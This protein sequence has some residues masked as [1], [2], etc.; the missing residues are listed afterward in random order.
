MAKR[1]LIINQNDK[2]G[3]LTFTGNI[4]YDEK[5]KRWL[6]EFICGCG[7][8]KQYRTDI[9]I[10]GKRKSCGCKSPTKNYNKNLHIFQD[11]YGYYILWNRIKKRAKESNIEFFITPDDIKNQF[12]EQNGKCF[13]THKNIRIPSN[14]T[15]LVDDDIASIDRTNSNIGYII[16]NI[17]LTTKT[18][19]MMKHTLSHE[20]FVNLCIIIQ[21]NFIHELFV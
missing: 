7:N 11:N 5:Y 15:N 18:I 6:G 20:E 14:F 16:N 4:I 3:N 19:N 17:K 2:F 13:Y 21:N 1:K 8:I 10:N 9:V 12:E